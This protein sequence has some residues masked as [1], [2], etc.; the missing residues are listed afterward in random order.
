MAVGLIKKTQNP[1][2]LMVKSLV[3]LKTGY[4]TFMKIFTIVLTLSNM[5]GIKIP[6]SKKMWTVM[7]LLLFLLTIPYSSIKGKILPLARL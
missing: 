7:L 4:S 5:L 2:L 6:N 1:I 3:K